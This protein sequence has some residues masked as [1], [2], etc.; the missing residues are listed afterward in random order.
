MRNRH[1]SNRTVLNKNGISI[2]IRHVIYSRDR[3]MY[4]HR[5]CE[6]ETPSRFDAWSGS[7]SQGRNCMQSMNIADDMDLY[8]DG[9]EKVV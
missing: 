2:G 8:L 3:K 4:L 1:S 9:E 7:K 6:T 5:G